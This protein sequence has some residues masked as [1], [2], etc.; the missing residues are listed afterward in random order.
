MSTYR[1]PCSLHLAEAEDTQNRPE[2]ISARKTHTHTHNGSLSQE[3]RADADW[4]ALA[5]DPLAVSW[6]PLRAVAGGLVVTAR[7]MD[8]DMSV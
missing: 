1:P 8:E 4:F 3:G 5:R 2:L 6:R 7:E